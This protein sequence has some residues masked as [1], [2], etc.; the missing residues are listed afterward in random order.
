MFF[1]KV[2]DKYHGVT[3]VLPSTQIQAI[4]ARKGYVD[5]NA[6][7]G[8]AVVSYETS[9]PQ[10]LLMTILSEIKS[11]SG[12]EMAVVDVDKIVGGAK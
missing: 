2:T 6:V 8:K 12:N 9:K 4:S 10:E 3:H 5:I 11:F 7:G 1:L